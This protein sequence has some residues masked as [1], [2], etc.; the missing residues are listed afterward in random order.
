M[1]FITKLKWNYVMSKI[2]FLKTTCYQKLVEKMVSGY[3][4]VRTAT[5][6]LFC[7]ERK[8]VK[9]PSDW[10]APY[11]QKAPKENIFYGH[12]LIRGY[13]RGY[14][15]CGALSAFGSEFKLD[16]VFSGLL[17][18]HFGSGLNRS[19]SYEID[20]PKKV[21]AF[22]PASTRIILNLAASSFTLIIESNKIHSVFVFFLM[23]IVF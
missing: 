16:I 8:T 14:C 12:C 3:F 13:I 6:S 23:P 19:V 1:V 2:L 4:V 22:C 18:L 7:A 5:M 11:D 17:A 21:R 10:E 20:T 9:L 15:S